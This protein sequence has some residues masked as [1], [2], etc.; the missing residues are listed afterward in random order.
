MLAYERAVCT[1]ISVRLVSY[2]TGFAPA[3]SSHDDT[4]HQ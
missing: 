1:D 2:F 3:K 4:M